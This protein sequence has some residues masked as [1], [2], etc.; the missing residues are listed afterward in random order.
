MIEV[1]D[2]RKS[3]G[4]T[5]AVA[6]ITFDVRAGETFGLLGPNGAGK[7]TT[8]AMLTGAIS[9]DSG[10]IR[11]ADGGPPNEAATRA[12]VGVAPQALSLYEELTAAENLT[13][14]GRLYGLNGTQLGERVDWALDFAGLSDRR[15]SYVKTFSGGMKRRLNLAVALVHDPQIIF[16]DEP[17]AGVD[18]QSRNHIFERIEALSAEGRTVIYTTH[19][20]EEAQRLCDR[21][22]IMDQG[23]ILDLDT[24][25]ALLARYGGR[26]VVKGEL[27][28]PPVNGVQLPGELDGLAL[29]FESERPLE[30]I[31]RLTT[32]GVAFQT[33]EVAK[34]DLETVFL[35]LTGRSLRD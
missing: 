23:K 14:F 24:I 17:T 3:F 16:L 18:P 27:V 1:R 12:K 20:M 11:L 4:T 15:K 2:L 30:E 22:A 21:V 13:F 19:Y 34:P 29:R 31:A 32:A 9:P 35:S 8:I 10:A 5:T 26:A 33:L 28:R 25:P 7:S 6:G